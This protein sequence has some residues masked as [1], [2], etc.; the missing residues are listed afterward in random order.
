MACPLPRGCDDQRQPD[1]PRKSAATCSTRR[2]DAARM[3]GWHLSE[4]CAGVLRNG[5]PCR[6]RAPSPRAEAWFGASLHW[7]PRRPVLR[8]RRPI[9]RTLCSADTN[10]V[11]TGPYCAIEERAAV[12][13]VAA[14]L[15]RAVGA[16]GRASS[17]GES[18]LADVVDAGCCVRLW[19]NPPAIGILHAVRPREVPPI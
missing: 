10:A 1:S 7:A 11:D 4:F 16:A 18:D 3:F 13:L 12:E 5:G 9:Q 6:G 19:A 15:L 14:L 17:S 2:L 8:T